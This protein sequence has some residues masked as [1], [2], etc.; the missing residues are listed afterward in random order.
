MTGIEDIYDFG[1]IRSKIV[2]GVDGGHQLNLF[3]RRALCGGAIV[4]LALTLG[5]CGRRGA[6]ELPPG[7]QPPAHGSAASA[8]ASQ[9]PSTERG[10]ASKKPDISIRPNKPFVLDPLL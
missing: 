2:N 7:I 1:S 6:L 5:A 4:A 8:T 3:A 10:A 9:P